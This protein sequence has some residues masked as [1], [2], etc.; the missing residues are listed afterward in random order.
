VSEEPNHIKW[1]QNVIANVVDPQAYTH[2]LSSN[3]NVA[4]VTL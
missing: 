2:Y 4:H 1:L 3:T